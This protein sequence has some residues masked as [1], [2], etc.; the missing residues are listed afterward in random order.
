[1]SVVERIAE[2]A[3]VFIPK[4]DGAAVSFCTPDDEFLTVSAHGVIESLVGL[5]VPMAD[6]FQ[7]LAVRTRQAQVTH[8]APHDQRLTPAIRDLNLR[9]GLQSWVVIPLL[10]GDVPIGTLLLTATR[11]DVFTQVDVDAMMSIS[12][13]ISALVGSQSEL[14]ALLGELMSR[15]DQTSQR[16]TARFLASVMLPEVAEL[17]GLQ[18]H[19][20]TLLDAPDHIG[21]V[22]QPIVDVHTGTPVGYEGLTRFP[23]AAHLDVAQW[24]GVA[25]KTGRGVSLELLALRT[26][27]NAAH[28]IP[29]D[30]LL[31]VNLSPAAALDPGV[32][33][34]LASARRPLMVEITEHEP[35][36]PDLSS[37]LAAL[38]DSGVRIAIDD[39]GA[40]YASFTQLLRL[41]PDVIK[42][43]G[44][45]IAGIDDD[46]AK[47]AL[48]AAV[49]QLAAELDATTIAESV[50]TPQQLDT[51]RRLRIH[52]GQGFH[53][54]RPGPVGE[55]VTPH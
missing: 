21:A 37:G 30:F 19:V 22:F 12:Q 54:G 49:V 41:R 52:W 9:L 3:C 16:F 46:P 20:D 17:D 42:I 48:A 47:R 38:R 13:F 18:A 50:E 40:G 15:A 51:L 5:T 43:D 35:F 25:R 24:F 29:D 23:A 36:P 33:D 53:L 44:E 34:V 8:D 39:A 14:S 55:L 31:A 10:H 11:S 6:S 2:Q 27:L 26:V 28:S 4:A 1:M 32:Q 45:L 7:G